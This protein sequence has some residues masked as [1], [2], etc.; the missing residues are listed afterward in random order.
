VN[1]K[2]TKPAEVDR[3]QA[4]TVLSRAVNIKTGGQMVRHAV[5]LYGQHLFHSKVQAQEIVLECP[6]SSALL[7]T[8][9][10]VTADN[11]QDNTTMSLTIIRLM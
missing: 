6:A 9:Y 7:M 1:R 11:T 10:T 2:R 4:H 3:K 8:C 5:L